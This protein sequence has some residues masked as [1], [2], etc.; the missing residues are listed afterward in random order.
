MVIHYRTV[1]LWSLSTVDGTSARLPFAFGCLVEAWQGKAARET[2]QQAMEF[3]FPQGTTELL[4]EF[5]TT[6]KL[7]VAQKENRHGSSS[8]WEHL[9]SEEKA[10][11]LL[12][13]IHKNAAQRE[14]VLANFPANGWACVMD[15][16]VEEQKGVVF[17]PLGSCTLAAGGTGEAIYLSRAG[18]H[19]K[20]AS[21]DWRTLSFEDVHFIEEAMN[22]LLLSV[23][24]LHCRNVVMRQ[25]ESA[26]PRRKRCVARHGVE[27]VRY[28]SLEIQAM[29]EVL[30][31]EGGMLGGERLPRALHICRGHFKTYQDLGLFGKYKGTFWVPMHLRGTAEEG[32][33]KKEYKVVAPPRQ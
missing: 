20:Q 31:A 3:F 29:R 15:V 32:V 23:S 25:S 8:V 21:P 28:Y 11:Y 1:I 13:R 7:S 10:Y 12:A 27:P 26:G 19:F 2:L 24:F 17:G 5:A 4:D 9:T 6:L 18:L 30:R 16:L 14:I 33:V 22:P